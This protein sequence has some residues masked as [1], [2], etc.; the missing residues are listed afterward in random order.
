[1]QQQQKLKRGRGFPLPPASPPPKKKN[2]NNNKTEEE[3][4]K[5]T[6]H[7]SLRYKTRY[8]TR[9]CCVLFKFSSNEVKVLQTK[10]MCVSDCSAMFCS[11]GAFSLTAAPLP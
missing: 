9:V 5:Q 10:R 7:K 2:D 11:F 3:K 1:M 8:C 4:N 6:K